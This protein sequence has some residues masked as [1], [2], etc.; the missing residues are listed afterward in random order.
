[1]KILCKSKDGGSESSVDAYWLIEWKG[2]FS[3]ALLR[4]GG[5]SRDAYHDHAFNSV[6]WLLSGQLREHFKHA[7]YERIYRP[8]LWPILTRRSTY[9][10]VD[11]IGVSW[12]LTF[13]GPWSQTWH[14]TDF[15]ERETTLTHGRK[16]V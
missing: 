9:H 12:V 11:S 14:E 7:M 16:V 8:S 1:M 2:V 6:S 5:R 10:L 15:Q 4:F 3:I 13:R